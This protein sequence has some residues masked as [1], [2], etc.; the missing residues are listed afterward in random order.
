MLN[1]KKEMIEDMIQST[2]DEVPGGHCEGLFKLY[3]GPKSN[4]TLVR[5]SVAKK[6]QSKSWIQTM[7]DYMKHIR[8]GVS[9]NEYDYTRQGR[10]SHYGIEIYKK[11]GGNIWYKFE[12]MPTASALDIQ[13]TYQHNKVDLLSQFKLNLKVA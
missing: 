10:V 3:T 12:P 2:I 1:I 5:V 6:G 8:D 7:N 11:Y 13:K 9:D 4:P